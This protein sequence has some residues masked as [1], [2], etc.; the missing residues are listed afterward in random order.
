MDWPLLIYTFLAGY[1]VAAFPAWLRARRRELLIE[2]LSWL[3]DDA[4]RAQ[5]P[6]P[7]DPPPPGPKVWTRT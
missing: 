5:V 3:L 4:R 2:R 7:A 1:L 6:P